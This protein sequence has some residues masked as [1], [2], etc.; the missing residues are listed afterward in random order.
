VNTISDP[1]AFGPE[2]VRGLEEDRKRAEAARGTLAAGEIGA[3]EHAKTWA[4]DLRR[5]LN[6]QGYTFD[7]A[8]VVIIAFGEDWC[9][10]AGTYPIHMGRAFG[11]AQPIVRRFDL[12]NPDCSPLLLGCSAVEQNL[13]MPGDIRLFIFKTSQGRLLAEFF[14]GMHG[15]WDK[16]RQVTVSFA[17]GSAR[18]VD[19]HGKPVGDAV[20]GA[21]VMGVGCGGHT[22]YSPTLVMAE[23]DV[24]LAAFRQALTQGVV[25]ER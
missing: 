13:P 11:L 3:W 18:V 17:A 21:V 15:L 4:E 6:A 25:T 5:K 12:M 14:E 16:P 1:K 8:Q 24:E 2:F 22:P 20:H 9:G 23:P 7:P 10:C 19:L